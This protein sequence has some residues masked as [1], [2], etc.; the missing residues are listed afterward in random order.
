MDDSD[1]DADAD[2]FPFTT[3]IPVRY[4]DL[5]TLNHVNNSVYSTYLEQGRIEYLQ[6][7]VGIDAGP[8]MVL[9]HV[10]ADYRAPIHLGQT[11]RVDVRVSDLGTSSFTF[12]Y[13]VRTDEGVALTGETVQVSVDPETGEPRPL[14][15]D[16]R[17]AIQEFESQN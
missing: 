13:R 17:A 16:W 7:V 11:A 14:P 2:D 9:V 1:A 12:D 8:Q 6:E 4:R 10:E 5:D 15:D 3:E